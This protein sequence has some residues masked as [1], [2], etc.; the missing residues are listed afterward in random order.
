M[1]QSMAFVRDLHQTG[2]K[3]EE[4][5]SKLYCRFMPDVTEQQ[6]DWMARH[7]LEQIRLFDASRRSLQEL[8]GRSEEESRTI[9]EKDIVGRMEGFVVTSQCRKLHSLNQAM[10]VLDELFRGTYTLEEAA[11][12]DP[13]GYRGNT[14]ER[15]RNRELQLVLDSLFAP[16]SKTEVQRAAEKAV[17]TLR[18]EWMDDSLFRGILTISLYAKMVNGAWPTELVGISVSIE[19]IAAAVCVLADHGEIDS[20]AVKMFL[21]AGFLAAGTATVMFVGSA[22]MI[23]AAYFLTVQMVGEFLLTED[24][25]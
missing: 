15:G 7:V 18:Q 22:V 6:G 16:L 13:A 8:S 19:Y 9:L 1:I 4:L 10:G 20:A 3:G 25:G 24:A 23:Y 17:G 5:L 21:L 12:M 11:R 14:G 2:A